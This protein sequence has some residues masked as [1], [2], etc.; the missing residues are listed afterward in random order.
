M[1]IGTA[2]S[3]TAAGR[4]ATTTANR[5]RERALSHRRRPWRRALLGVLA[6]GV[7]ALLGWVV[8][9]STALGVQHV[10][11]S[12][13]EGAEAAAVSELVAVAPGTPLLR[14][15]TDAVGARVRERVT[16]AEVSVRRS[17]PRTLSVDVVPR[18]AALVMRNPEGQ[19]E[20]VDATGV[21]FGVVKAAP[22]G[23]PVVTATGA[24]GTS[25]D[26]LRASLA[27]L[28]ALPEDLASQVS[29]VRV[30]SAN[31]VSFTLGSRTV[32]WGG[33]EDSAR[34]ATILSALLPTAAK[35]IDVSAPDTPVTR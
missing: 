4:G 24:A 8:G 5:F 22:K 16:V 9:F 13:V 34:K 21:A 32:V 28:D 19:L 12:G 15:D 20:V 25:R 29:A 1:S 27:L 33:G 3:S 31:L 10:E 14:V 26:A 6:V 35:V 2:R 17:W 30:S 11:V 23:V 18:T 7:C